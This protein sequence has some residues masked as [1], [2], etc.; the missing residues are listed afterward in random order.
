[1]LTRQPFTI[2]FVAQDSAY[3]RAA[4]TPLFMAYEEISFDLQ[5]NGVD[6]FH[7][8]IMPTRKSFHETLR[9]RLPAWTG[10]FANPLI[11]TMVIKSPRWNPD[12]SFETT[13]IHE[14]FHL[15]IHQHLGAKLP[16]W[17]DEGLAI[18]YSRQERWKTGTALAKAVA[19]GSIIPLS[20]IDYVLDYHQI[21]ADL[22]YQ[23]SFSAVDYLLR[24]YDIDALRQII[25]GL[26]QGQSLDACFISATGSAF[27]DFEIEWQNHIRQTS[28]WVWLFELDDYLWIAIFI[29]L[30]SAFILRKVHNRRIEERWRLESEETERNE[31]EDNL[32]L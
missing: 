2:H 12:D 3:A 29:L 13:L 17:L 32:L 7:V 19:T 4:F 18:F 9:G 11:N 23:Q 25:K 26:K 6:S 27:A 28:K 20:E 21:K 1:M 14:F 8:Y 15:L 24:T 30:V 5:L 16:R 31:E 22:A 10:A